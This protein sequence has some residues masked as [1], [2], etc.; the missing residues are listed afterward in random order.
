MRI[1][2]GF[3]SPAADFSQHTLD[4]NELVVQHPAATYY[5]QVQG[6]SMLGAGITTGDILVVDRALEATEGSIVVAVVDGEFTVKRVH[7]QQGQ[8]ELH[9]ENERYK[10][11]VVR[12]GMSVELWGVVTYVIHKAK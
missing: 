12:E 4:L 7:Y 6:Y 10:S 11:I 1:P 5:V 2:A 8:L 9:A 3:P